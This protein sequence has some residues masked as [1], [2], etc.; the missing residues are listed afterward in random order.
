MPYIHSGERSSSPSEDGYR[1]SATFDAPHIIDPEDYPAVNFPGYSEKPLNEQLEPIAVIG[2]GKDNIRTFLPM[3]L[4]YNAPSLNISFLNLRLPL[5]SAS[6][7]SH[8]LQ[9][10][11]N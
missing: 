3:H 9:T 11:F 8:L 7:K 5:M 10:E 6:S 2:M 1:P 4:P